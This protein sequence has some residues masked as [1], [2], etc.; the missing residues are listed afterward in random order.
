[1]D[2]SWAWILPRFN[3]HIVVSNAY[4]HDRTNIKSSL[5]HQWEL[6]LLPATDWTFQ[7]TFYHRN[8]YLGE[9]PVLLSCTLSVFAL[10]VKILI[11]LTWRYSKLEESYIYKILLL[12]ILKNDQLTCYS[13]HV[14]NFTLSCTLWIFALS[15]QFTT[16]FYS[17]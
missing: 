16:S 9:V 7:V 13:Y 8:F 3:D 4:T 12:I 10:S 17:L 1:M 2:F 6:L 11:K 15:L 14:K 5:H